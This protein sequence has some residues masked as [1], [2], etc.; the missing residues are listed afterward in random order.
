MSEAWSVVIK[1]HS[2]D[3]KAEAKKFAIEAACT[4]QTIPRS[5]D[6]ATSIKFEPNELES[7]W[8]PM[9]T[10]PKDGTTVLVAHEHWRGCGIAQYLGA[11]GWRH[12]SSDTRINHPEKLTH[13]MPLPSPPAS[14]GPE[15]PQ[16]PS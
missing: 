6:L 1:V 2:F 10:A 12:L 8:Q 11:D 15:M 16:T 5:K 7:E 4:F 13:W 9:A 3:S 14:P